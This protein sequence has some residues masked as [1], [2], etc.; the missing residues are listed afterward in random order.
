[1]LTGKTVLIGITG[2]IA[3]YKTCELIRLFKKN[4]AKVKVIVTPNA[5]NFVTKT[6]LETLSQNP[7]EIEQFDVKEYKPEHIAL[8]DESDIFVIAPASANTIAKMT[9]GVCDNLLTSTFCAYKKPVVIAPCMNTNMWEN[10]A[11]VKNIETLKERGIKVIEPETGF[12]A[13]GT[14]GKGRLADIN[15]IFETAKNILLPEQFLKGKKI[16]ITAGGTKEDIDTVRYIG[17]YS[18]GKMGIALADNAYKLGG[19]VVLITTAEADKKYKVINVKTAQE[20]FDAVKAEFKDAYSL[21]MAAAVSDYRVKNKSEHK[22]KKDGGSL[23]LEL[24]ENPDIL[25]EMCKIKKDN[26]LIVGFCAESENLIENAKT[27]IKKKG[28]DY[29]CANDISR[30]DTGFSSNYNELYIIDKELNITHI[31]KT[32]KNNAAFKIMDKIYGKSK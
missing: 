17:N 7:V 24:V 6:T 11:T 15:T 1:M 28:C 14:E 22:I 23:T 18:S 4:N 25:E 32:D 30:K 16:V 20:M 2:A 10:P 13:C 9:L 29:I 31:E 12:L 3:A 27:K 21:I 5:L 19:D 8:T 26:Q